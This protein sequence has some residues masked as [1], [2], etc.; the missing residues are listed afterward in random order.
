MNLIKQEYQPLPPPC[1]SAESED[2]RN[3]LVQSALA[4]TAIATADQNSV[5]RNVAVELRNYLK[6]VESARVQLTK[7]LLEG[8]RLLKALADDHVGPIKEELA[9]LE[10]L[11]TV[12]AV[13]EEK[14]V[15]AEM[16]ARLE[17]AAEAKTDSEFAIISN[18]PLPEAERARGQTLR[19]VM[20]WEITDIH[21]L[22]AA[23]RGC[24]KLEPSASGIAVLCVPEM[25]TP[26]IRCWWEDK[27]SYTTR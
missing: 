23:K 14:R 13:A 3:E 10:R 25:E 27:S 5:A 21:A 26:G 9:R 16:K 7:P 18:E 22:Y 24:V 11:G 1:I 6:S 8:Q 12:W 20:K 19:Q 17:L 2:A 15:A 4:I